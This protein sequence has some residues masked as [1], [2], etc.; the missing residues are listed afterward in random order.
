MVVYLEYH[1]EEANS[2]KF[3]QATIE[4]TRGIGPKC[5]A[6]TRWGR[7]GSKG[8][9]KLVHFSTEG[10]ALEFCLKKKEEKIAKGYK[11]VPGGIIAD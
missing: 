9:S 10:Q 11:E 7:I 2:H 5:T 3:W 1:D 4:D 6:N 8:Q